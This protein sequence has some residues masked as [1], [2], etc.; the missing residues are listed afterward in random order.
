MLIQ[1]E[2]P[3]EDLDYILE[4]FKE[5]SN[6]EEDSK[7]IIFEKIIVIVRDAKGNIVEKR[8]QKMR[9]LTQYYLALMSIPL[10]GTY[11]GGTGAVATSIL[12]SILGLPNAQGTYQG[13]SAEI[14]FDM[15]IQ[16][17]SGTQSFSPTLTGLNAPI[18]NGS[19]TGQLI[20][21]SQSISY[22]SNSISQLL[23]VSNNTSSSITV[24]EIGLIGTVY[25]VYYNSSAL[26]TH[27]SYNFLLSYDTFSSAVNIPAG[28]SASFQ[29]V[30]TFSG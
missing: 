13:D 7:K 2:I 3:K 22:T 1:N 6:K 19:G 8:T 29:I 20:Y 10:L 16:L 30:I 17:G 25:L 11:S 21:N 5:D 9:S 12:T 15:S 18:S 24:S 4:P 14:N 28:G 26:Y 27:S 23:T